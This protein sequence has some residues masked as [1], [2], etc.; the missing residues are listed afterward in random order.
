MLERVAHAAL[1]MMLLILVVFAV[2]RL[3]GDPTFALLPEDATQEQREQLR[4]DLGLDEPLVVQYFIF[5]GNLARGDLGTSFQYGVPVS[6]LIQ[7]R[8][9]MTALLAVAAIT[10]TICVGIPLG[11]YAAYKRGGWVDRGAR[12]VAVGG[13]SAPSFWVGLLLIY[14]LA[15][16]LRWLPAG[17]YGGPSHLVL[18]AITVGWAAVAGLT[19]LTRSSMIEVLETDYIK[20]LR[21]KGVPERRVVWRHGLRNAGLS[22]LTFTGVLTAGLLTGSIVAE[23]VFV[24]PGMGLLISE[25]ITGRDFAVVQGVVLVFSAIYIVVNLVVDLLYAALNPRLR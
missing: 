19:R 4:D 1:S 5:L 10:L 11:V 13:Q 3:T 21:L 8:F 20:F 9:P 6:T 23:T 25:S 24:W 2:V 12:L 16:W 15:I 17:G 18:P 14:L 22:A 7:Q